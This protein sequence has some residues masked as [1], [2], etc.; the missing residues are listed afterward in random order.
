VI[1]GA[2]DPATI[3]GVEVDQPFTSLRQIIDENLQVP[4]GPELFTFGL[5]EEFDIPQIEALVAQP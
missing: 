2:L 1:A 4:D 3:A 5:L